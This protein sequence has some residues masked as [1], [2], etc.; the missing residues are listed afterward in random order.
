MQSA[1]FHIAIFDNIV[2]YLM[3]AIDLQF[4]QFI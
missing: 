3:H 1:E 2:L 4:T